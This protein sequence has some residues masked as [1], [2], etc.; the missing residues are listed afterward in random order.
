MGRRP[1]A[2]PGPS[3]PAGYGVSPTSGLRGSE[4]S[5][6]C[7][8]RPSNRKDML[9]GRRA[10]PLAPV[11]CLMALSDEHPTTDLR[12]TTIMRVLVAFEGVRSVYSRTI[13]RAISELRSGL[14]VRSSGLERLKEELESFDPHVVV[15]S[16]PNGEHPGLRGA[17]VQ[18]PTDDDLEE[19]ERLARICLDGEMWRTDGPPLSELL[20]VLDETQKRLHEGHLSEAC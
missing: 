15:S 7:S 17:W 5:A 8:R 9:H 16:R 1:S 11:R 10:E 20:E 14:D 12:R 3:G 2:S 19:G 4:R 13:I 18:I 6:L